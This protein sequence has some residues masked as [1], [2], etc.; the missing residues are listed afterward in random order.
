MGFHWRLSAFNGDYL[1][2]VFISDHRFKIVF[3]GF[4]L[5]LRVFIGHYGILMA[6]LGF[7]GP[8]SV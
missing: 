6:S 2:W 7:Y 5:L 3:M 4:Y 8:L 1:V